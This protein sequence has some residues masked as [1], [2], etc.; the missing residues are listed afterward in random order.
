MIVTDISQHDYPH[1]VRAAQLSDN[2]FRCGLSHDWLA[3]GLAQRAAQAHWPQFGQPT[4]MDQEQGWISAVGLNVPEC[5]GK[6]PS[7]SEKP[8]GPKL[9]SG[10]VDV[11]RVRL[12]APIEIISA[13]SILSSEEL[14]HAGRFHFE[15]DR[16]HFA[17]CRSVLRFLL[18]GYL[19]VPPAEILFEYQPSGKPEL[20]AQQNLRQLR[21]NVSHSAGLAVI[22]VSAGQRIG[23]D[24]E[25]I[26][27]DVDITTL[28]DRV[29]SA[30]ERAGLRDLPGYLR[31]PAF[32]ACWTRKESF[33]KATGDGLTFPLAD[34]SVTTHPGLEPALEE[35]HGN[36]EA[37]KKWFLADLS[38]T[39][40]Y[41]ATVAVEGFYPR[42]R[43]LR[44]RLN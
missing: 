31:V 30:Q 2:L 4:S 27:A 39:D 18:S 22:A 41:R 34:F 14:T 36:T 10:H 38:V 32:F 37:R 42:R 28:A 1:I 16:L 21:F 8:A 29:F 11:W 20:A 6:S 43:I 3:R 19:K 15:K 26:R 9:S 44:P 33:L 17:R 25:K 40:G 7:W 35:I 23:I 5:P 12:D 24:I 13:S